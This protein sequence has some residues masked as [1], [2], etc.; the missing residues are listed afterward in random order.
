MTNCKEFVL[1]DVMAI[2]AIPLSNISLGVT[3]WQVTPVIPEDDFSPSLDNAITIGVQPATVGGKLIPIMRATGK[4][5]DDESD[6][7][8]GRT[9]TVTVT[10]EVDSRDIEIWGHLLIL[11]R[12]PAHLLLSFRDE[13]RAFVAA[14]EDTYLCTTDRDGSKTSVTFKIHN[15]MGIQ[16]ITSSSV[17]P[18]T[19][20]II[21]HQDTTGVQ[22][23]WLETDDKS[24]AYI[25]NKPVLDVDTDSETL[26]ID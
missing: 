3:P 23:D 16:I 25:K 24:M 15:L 18:Y 13:S 8:A 7:V 26:V 6:S 11:E 5:K 12:A 4:A 10:C 20:D 2:T 21:I 1:D 9:H 17:D 22:S 14:S 19:H